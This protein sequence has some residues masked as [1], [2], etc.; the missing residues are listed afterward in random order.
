V[1]V[2]RTGENTKEVIDRVKQKI[3]EIEPGLPPG[4]HIIPFYDRSQLIEAT[5]DTLRHALLEEIILVTLAHIIFLVY[6][7]RAESR[8]GHLAPEER[9]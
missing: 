1:I 5:V 6:Q 2:A 9:Q 7:Y 8:H 4:V 3:K